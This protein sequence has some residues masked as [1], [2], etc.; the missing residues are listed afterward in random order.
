MLHFSCTVAILIEINWFLHA[1]FSDTETMVSAMIMKA[2]EIE[3]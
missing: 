1:P 2:A 3:T